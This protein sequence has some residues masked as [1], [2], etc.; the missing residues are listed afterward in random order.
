MIDF[1]W[2]NCT[3]WALIL[4]GFSTAASAQV[5]NCGDGV[6]NDGDGLIDCYDGDCQGSGDCEGF[7]FNP[8]EPECGY[9]PAPLEEVELGQLFK[10]DEGRYP[11]DQRAGVVVGDLDGDGVAELVSRDNG[12]PRIQIFDGATGALKQSILTPTTHPFG[13]L[14]IADVDR[15]GVGDIFHCEFYGRLARYE[16]GNPNAIW[17]TGNYVGDDNLVSTPQIADINQDGTPEILV[18][19]RIFD[20]LTGVRYVDGR[21]HGKRRCLQRG[22]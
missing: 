17:R 12:P 16:F 20:A 7:F 8:P 13:Q 4:C 15:D 14:A 11:I 19:D 2:L 22:Q 10:T 1:H 6:D 3:V 5:E 9:R 21:L 18:G